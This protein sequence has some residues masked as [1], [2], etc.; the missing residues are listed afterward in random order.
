M[1]RR[2][3]NIA[4]WPSGN[5]ISRLEPATLEVRISSPRSAATRSRNETGP[6]SRAIERGQIEAS[7]EREAATI[8]AHADADFVEQ[9]ADRDAGHLSMG[10]TR[11]VCE[12]LLDN[13]V[14]V[15]AQGPRNSP[16][17]LMTNW[18]RSGHC[19]PMRSRS[20]SSAAPNSQTDAPDV[21]A[22]GLSL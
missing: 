17:P 22:A 6:S 4:S 13:A 5:V 2:F 7:V 15:V 11:D 21:A 12:A 8:V 10:M 18:M 1:A 3:Q 16:R 9:D 19:C 20:C 14:D